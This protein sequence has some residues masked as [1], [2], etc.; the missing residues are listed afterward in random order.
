VGSFILR[1]TLYVE[2]RDIVIP[3]D[4]QDDMAAEAKAEREKDAR[5]VLAE[6]ESDI[7]SM[8]LEA[9]RIYRED[10]LAFKLRSMHLLNEGVKES[11]GTIVV[12]S[13]YAEGFTEGMAKRVEGLTE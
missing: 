9:T 10:E 4:L 5:I 8:L 7:A 6:V 1:N 3:K 13:V 2:I 12:P 11:R